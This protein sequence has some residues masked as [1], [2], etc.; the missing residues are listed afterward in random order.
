MISIQFSRGPDFSSDLI[1]WFSHASIASGFSHVDTV[2]PDGSL[3]GARSDS[4]GGKPPGVQIRPANYLGTEPVFRVDIE[5]A[6]ELESSAYYDFVKS[7]IGKPYDMEGIAGFITD[8]DWRDPSSWFC[9]ELV[10]A[11][12]ERCQYF[13]YALAAPLNKVTPVDLLRFLSVLQPL[14]VPA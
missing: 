9:S 10:T 12:L 1:M 2:M 13:P 4:I 3:L 14:Q 8:R 6:N 7:Q 5:M 11:G